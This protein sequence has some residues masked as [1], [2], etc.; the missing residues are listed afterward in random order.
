MPEKSLETKIILWKYGHWSCVPNLIIVKFLERVFSRSK[1][2]VFLFILKSRVLIFIYPTFSYVFS[3]K[4]TRHY[5]LRLTFPVFSS[6]RRYLGHP[7][8]GTEWKVRLFF[9]QNIL[10]LPYMCAYLFNYFKGKFVVPLNYCIIPSLSRKGVGPEKSALS[11]QNL[12]YSCTRFT[13][14]G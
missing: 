6:R 5:I 10:S 7:F 11:V 4:Y 2:S 3:Q 14:N 13:S 9:G 8:S 12:I 1:I